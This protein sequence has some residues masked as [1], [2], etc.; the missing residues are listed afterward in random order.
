MVRREGKKERSVCARSPSALGAAVRVRRL[1]I[2]LRLRLRHLL[3]VLHPSS[4]GYL[5]EYRNPEVV[6]EPATA[7][8]CAGYSTTSTR[9]GTRYRTPHELTYRKL[10]PKK[11]PKI[12]S[13]Y[14]GWTYDRAD[15]EW[16]LFRSTLWQ[17]A[18]ALA[19]HSAVFQ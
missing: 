9:A 14:S 16:V 13:Y 10:I 18:G 15:S 12:C 17:L 3:Q 11:T 8:C 2:P 19:A 4:H 5:T 7:P 1:G 6:P